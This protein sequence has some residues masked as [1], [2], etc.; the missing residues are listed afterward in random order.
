[1]VRLTASAV[2]GVPLETRA[3]PANLVNETPN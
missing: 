2:Q 3:A 1:M